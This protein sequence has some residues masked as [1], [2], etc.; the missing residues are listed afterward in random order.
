MPVCQVHQHAYTRVCSECTVDAYRNGVKSR[1]G[2]MFIFS[3]YWGTWSRVLR[4]GNASIPTVEVDLTAINPNSDLAWP[5]VRAINIR[6]HRTARSAKDELSLAL[7]DYAFDLMKSRM[8]DQQLLDRLL[9]EDLLPLIDWQ[10]YQLA[11]NGGAALADILK[12]EVTC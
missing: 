4:A 3:S 7:P 6:E 9:H 8:P 2:D 12:G 10:K 1:N 5:K 11:C